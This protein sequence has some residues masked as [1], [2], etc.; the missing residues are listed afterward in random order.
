MRLC[1]R[2]STKLS[3]WM[4]SDEAIQPCPY[5]HVLCGWMDRRG[6]S[7]SA[8]VNSRV[9]GSVRPVYYRVTCALSPGLTKSSAQGPCVLI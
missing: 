6:G 8:R 2:Y 9:N 5:N 7:S 4:F 3:Q 1:L